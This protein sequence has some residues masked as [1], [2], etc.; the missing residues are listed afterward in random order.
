MEQLSKELVIPE[1]KLKV[2]H[3]VFTALFVSTVHHYKES[4]DIKV[5]IRP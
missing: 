3:S 1:N 5:E 2:I 4:G